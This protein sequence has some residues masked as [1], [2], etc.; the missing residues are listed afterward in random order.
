MSSIV[1]HLIVFLINF[2]VELQNK[3]L[4]VSLHTS[5]VLQKLRKVLGKTCFVKT[6]LQRTSASS[7]TNMQE[8]KMYIQ[9][10]SIYCL[11]STNSIRLHT[12]VR[13][14]FEEIYKRVF[15]LLF[16]F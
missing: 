8:H 15:L 5:A 13:V 11:N 12:Y 10:L 14:N 3:S 6:D 2:V 1:V 9:N 4:Y 16:F 7:T